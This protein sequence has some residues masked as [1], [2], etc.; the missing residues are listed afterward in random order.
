VTIIMVLSGPPRAADMMFPV[1]CSHLAAAYSG[2]NELYDASRA[3]GL[4]TRRC[5]G[6]CYW[7]S[8]RLAFGMILEPP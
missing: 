6:A 7:S 2:Y 8:M 1:I 5:V 3:P 4:I